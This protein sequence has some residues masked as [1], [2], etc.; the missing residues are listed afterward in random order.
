MCTA[1]CASSRPWPL[2]AMIACP[3]PCMAQPRAAHLASS[4]DHSA[5]ATPSVCSDSIDREGADQDDLDPE[6]WE[7]EGGSRG[8]D[9]Y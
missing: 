9:E 4:D 7:G 2:A 8:G 6:D 1:E 5:P 3:A